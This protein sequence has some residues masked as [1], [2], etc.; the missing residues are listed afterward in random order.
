VALVGIGKMLEAAEQAA[1]LLAEEAGIEATVWDPRVVVPLDPDMVADLAR[2]RVVVTA[3][4]GMRDG[5]IGMAV[6]DAVNALRLGEGREPVTTVVLGT[7]TRFLLQ[8]KPQ[9]ILAELG[10][11]AAGI[12]TAAASAWKGVAH[13]PTPSATG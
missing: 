5:G 7:P 2:H 3:E 12:F 10:L 4:D 9:Q 1:V 6:V 13:G 8:G 11:D